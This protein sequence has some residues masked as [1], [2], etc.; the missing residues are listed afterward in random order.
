MSKCMTSFG[1]E[2]NIAEGNIKARLRM[3]TAYHMAN[4]FKGCV[5]STDNYSEYNMGFWTLHGDVGDISPIQF[6]NK[7]FELQYIAKALGIPDNIITQAPS[8]GLGV[9]ATNTDEAQLGANYKFVDSAM[10]LYMPQTSGSIKNQINKHERAIY[11]KLI[12]QIQDS[13][14]YKKIIAQF[15]RTQH[16]R[17]V[18]FNNNLF[19]VEE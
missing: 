17:H 12:D 14:K 19:Q 4:I 3:I 1:I 15:E 18:N 16:K 11:L 13:N 7:G 10:L 6:I 9:T 8:D 2:S 5:L